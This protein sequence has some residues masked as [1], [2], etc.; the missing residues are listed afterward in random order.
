VETLEQLLNAMGERLELGVRPL[1]REYDPLHRRAMAE[2]APEERLALAISWN[3]LAGR[4]TAAGN[5]ARQ[6]QDPTATARR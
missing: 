6:E 3:R 2:R 1:E 5:Q 4:L